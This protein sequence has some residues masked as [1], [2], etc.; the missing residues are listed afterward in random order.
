MVAKGK[1]ERALKIFQHALALDPGH[2]DI[3]T[4]YGEFL[5]HNQADI[6]EAERLYC[7][8]LVASPSHTRALGNY[9]RTAPLVNEID[10]SH[11]VRIDQK[12]DMLLHVPDSHPALRR[13]VE[14][15][16]FRHLYHATALEGNTFTLAQTRSFIETRIVVAGK[17]IME[18]NELLGMEAALAFLNSSLIKRIG[19]I[20]VRDI[21]DIHHRVLGY[22]DPVGAGVFRTSQAIVLVHCVS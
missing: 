1:S 16:Y 8:A 7:Q 2:P 12:R 13:L 11:F 22:V 20:T 18:H 10:Q 17:S 6:V 4:E 21:L 14:E 9:R 5:E 19:A 3:L 15:N